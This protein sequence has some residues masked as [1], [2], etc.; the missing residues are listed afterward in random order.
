MGGRANSRRR[1]ADRRRHPGARLRVDAYPHGRV[2][3]IDKRGDRDWFGDSWG[4]V[5]C[6][7]CGS[8]AWHRLHDVRDGCGRR[9]QR[10]DR[11]C[12]HDDG[13]GPAAAAD[14]ADAAVSVPVA[15]AA[16]DSIAAVS[17]NA[18]AATLATAAADAASTSQ[19]AAASTSQPAVLYGPCSINL[20]SYFF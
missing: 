6:R 7:C 10:I 12:E 17:C 4:A 19:P 1:L 3:V 14:T 20:D 11:G 15:I 18:A 2:A 9:R 8:C 16:A 5:H 13:P